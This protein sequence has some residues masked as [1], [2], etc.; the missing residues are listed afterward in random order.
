MG[1]I[2]LA[3]D[4]ARKLRNTSAGEPL[5]GEDRPC[6]RNIIRCGFTPAYER[7]NWSFPA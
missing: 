4:K 1:M 5:P 6:Y 3:V 7:A 2:G